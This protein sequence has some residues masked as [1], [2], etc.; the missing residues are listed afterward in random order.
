MGDIV[1][2]VLRMLFSLLSPIEY[3]YSIIDSTKFTDWFKGAAEHYSL[4]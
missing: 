4:M 3:D 1:E 2:R